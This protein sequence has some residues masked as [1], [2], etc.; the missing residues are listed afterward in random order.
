MA[1]GDLDIKTMHLVELHAQVGDAGAGFLAGL[2]VQQKAVAIGLDGPQLVQL[3]VKAVG[4][5][6]PIT[7]QGGGLGRDGALQQVG[8]P[9]GGLQLAEN[10]SQIGLWR[11]CRKRKQL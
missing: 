1:A 8:A 9:G 7:H 4:N 5:H 3:G 10:L 11:L 2:Q 6:A